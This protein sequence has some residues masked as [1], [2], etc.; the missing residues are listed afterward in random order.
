MSYG[1]VKKFGGDILEESKTEADRKDTGTT[2]S[3]TLPIA[4]ATPDDDEE[5]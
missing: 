2:F 1:I 3:V 4:D 5:E